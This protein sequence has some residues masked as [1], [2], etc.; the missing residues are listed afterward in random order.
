MQF[1]FSIFLDAF[2]LLIFDFYR[3]KCCIFCLILYV[4]SNYLFYMQEMIL[5]KKNIAGSKN[6]DEL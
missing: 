6:K 4:V 3:V 5:T 1:S 2:Q